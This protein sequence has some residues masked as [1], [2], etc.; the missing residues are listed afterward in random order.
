MVGEDDE[1][2]ARLAIGGDDVLGGPVPVRSIRVTV[3]IAAE[4]TSSSATQKFLTH[5]HAPS[6]LAR[7]PVR[8]ASGKT[9]AMGRTFHFRVR[10]I[11][12]S[13]VMPRRSRSRTAVW[14]R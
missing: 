9:F 7:W 11:A 1:V 13:A 2:V 10:L 6:L 4:E 3:E 14:R 8:C 5:G 12:E